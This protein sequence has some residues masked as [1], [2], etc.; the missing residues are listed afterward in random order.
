MS[1]LIGE[2]M[3]GGYGSADNILKGC[4]IA[5]EKGQIA[6]IVGPLAFPSAMVVFDGPVLIAAC[7]M[8]IFFML[9]GRGITRREG[10]A[11]A[12]AYLVYIA[13]RFAYGLI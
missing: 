6:V 3:V 9:S 8:M 5:V 13:A 1:F 12:I 11:M 4:T 10:A 2:N 7:A